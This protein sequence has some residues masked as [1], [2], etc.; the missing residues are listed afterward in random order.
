MIQLG[1]RKLAQF[2][3][4]HWMAWI[5]AA[6]VSY[7][8]SSYL[9]VAVA[10]TLRVINPSIGPADTLALLW[11]RV[12]AVILA[13]SLLL[14]VPSLIKSVPVSIADMA[15]SRLPLWKDVGMALAGGVVYIAT[16]TA[17]FVIASRFTL[18]DTAQAQDVGRTTFFGTEGAWAF[19]ILIVAVPIAEELLFRG[20]LYSKLRQAGGGYWPAALTVS[21]LFALAHGQVNVGVDVFF[22]SMVACY[23]RESTGSIWAGILLHMIK[24]AVAFYIAF[25]FMP[26]IGS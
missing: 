18:F 17:A 6:I 26:A 16:T 11:Y 15:I 9:V 2:R 12:I 4:L 1:F 5:I 21:V 8:A 7:I 3:Y 24:N 10:Y 20:L 13:I 19:L 14:L 23:L 25:S 22:L